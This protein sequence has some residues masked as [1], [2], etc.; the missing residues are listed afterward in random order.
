MSK[1]T[2]LARC[3]VTVRVG[4][5]GFLKAV[6]TTAYSEEADLSPVHVMSGTIISVHSKLTSPKAGYCLTLLLF[7]INTLSNFENADNLLK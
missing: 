3:A 6:N 4:S 2:Q 5:Y 1:E 7:S